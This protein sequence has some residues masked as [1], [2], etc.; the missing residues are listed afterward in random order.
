MP[1]ATTEPCD[2]AAMKP[3][4]WE[5][6]NRAKSNGKRAKQLRRSVPGWALGLEE[7]GFHRWIRAINY[8]PPAGSR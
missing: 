3:S 7:D 5:T 8:L 4:S 6:K 1:L 2:R